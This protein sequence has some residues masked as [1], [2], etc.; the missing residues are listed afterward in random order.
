MIFIKSILIDRTV[1]FPGLPVQG[2]GVNPGRGEDIQRGFKSI[3]I[4]GRKRPVH[5]YFRLFSL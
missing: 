2:G 3:N 1:P 5:F 4:R